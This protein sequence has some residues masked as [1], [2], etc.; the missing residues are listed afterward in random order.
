MRDEC[1]QQSV[2]RRSPK[3]TI[4]G[5]RK[6]TSILHPASLSF[7]LVG[8]LITTFAASTLYHSEKQTLGFR[9]EANIAKVQEAISDRM[10]AYSQVLRSGVAFIS[11]SDEVTRNE[12]NTFVT[13]LNL[14]NVYPGMQGMGFIRV[15]DPSEKVD[16]EKKNRREGIDDFSVWPIQDRSTLTS[17]EFI[18]PLNDRN[19]RSLGYDMMADATRAIAMGR[20]RDSGEPALSGSVIL[21]Q[22]LETELR[23]GFLLFLPVYEGGKRPTSIEKRRGAIVGYVYSAFRMNDFM[24]GLF[25]DLTNELGVK[26]YDA[27]SARGTTAIHAESTDAAPAF[28]TTM[29]IRVAGHTWTVNVFSLPDFENLLPRLSALA[30]ALAGAALTLLGMIILADSKSTQEKATRIAEAMTETLREREADVTRLNKDLEKEVALRTAR[31][32]EA[33]AELKSFSYTVSHDLK[34]PVR[35]IN[36]LTEFL[37]EDHGDELSENASDYLNR[38]KR[39][40]AHM[41]Q[42]IDDILTLATC[43]DAKFRRDEI[44]ITAVATEISSTI[45]NASPDR[46]I[47]F[48]IEPGMKANADSTVVRT[49]FQNLIENAVKFSATRQETLIEIGT[50]PHPF[51]FEFYVKDNGV[52]FDMKYSEKVFT[53]FKRLHTEPEYS[54]TGV[55]MATVRKL[56]SRHRGWIRVE[57]EKDKGTTF[58]FSFGKSDR[59]QETDLDSISP[60]HKPGRS[61]QPCTNTAASTTQAISP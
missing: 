54:G 27:D 42:L 16:F 43:A 34:T 7:A 33:N 47:K 26:I 53:L 58:Y 14:D 22:E 45:E 35:H 17:V 15:I 3:E 51:G 49:T 20:A 39:A 5:S 44:D 32:E 18:E 2:D 61:S 52:G 31:L 38:I 36:T 24:D 48:Q 9:F 46:S 4:F 10:Q 29:D 23:P 6:L 28:N 57:S 19:R 25:G 59:S 8:L 13:S 56:I 60:H 37:V 30:I 41:N 11:S 40:A 21:K 50:A 55:G 12:W 1:P